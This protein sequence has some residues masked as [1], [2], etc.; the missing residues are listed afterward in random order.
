MKTCASSAAKLSPRSVLWP[1]C[2]RNESVFL[3]KGRDHAPVA[4]AGN[5]FSGGAPRVGST[6]NE[7]RDEMEMA[8][9]AAKM[10]LEVLE[11]EKEE[12]RGGST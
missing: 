10:R 8:F 6:V 7:L 1:R 3:E 9:E 5:T 12:E 11:A 4:Y 2:R